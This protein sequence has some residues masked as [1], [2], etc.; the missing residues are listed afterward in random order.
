MVFEPQ[1]PFERIRFAL[2]GLVKMLYKI[3]TNFTALTIS[4]ILIRL[5]PKRGFVP[6]SLIDCCELRW[7]S[8]RSGRKSHPNRAS[9]NQQLKS[10]IPIVFIDNHGYFFDTA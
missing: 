9:A 7:F 4:N 3:N 5:I 10:R 8:V 6:A 1:S 2:Q